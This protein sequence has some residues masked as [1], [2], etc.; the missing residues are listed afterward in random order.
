MIPFSFM[1]SEA[2]EIPTSLTTLAEDGR[3]IRR[4]VRVRHELRQPSWEMDEQAGIP[5]ISSTACSTRRDGILRFPGFLAAAYRFFHAV[6]A[7]EAVANPGP[8]MRAWTCG[9]LII[10]RSFASHA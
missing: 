5:R 1:G 10:P 9:A 8:I 2:A 6:L 3:L 4:G 7:V